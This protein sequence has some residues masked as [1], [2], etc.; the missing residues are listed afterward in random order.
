MKLEGRTALVTGGSRGIGRAACLAFAREGCD[1]VVNFAREADR[2]NAVVAE[3]ESLGRRALAAQGDVASE[4]EVDSVL[5]AVA[6]FVGD[7]GLNILFNNAGIYPRAT[8]EDVSV[9]EWDRVIGVN[10]RGPFLCT[11][12]A[13]PLLKAATPGRIINIGSVIPALGI[14]GAIHYSASKGAV[15]GFTHSLSRELAAFGIN[16]NCLVPSL[17]ETETTRRDYADLTDAVV[18]GQS[19][20]RY[21]QPGDL[22]GAL[23][24]LASDDSEFMTGQTLVVDGGRLLL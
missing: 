3:I 11:R 9:D 13:L 8:I 20:S 22:Q 2:A 23:V 6:E 1:V 5:A 12:A 10:V 4:D 19:V 16:V 14:P 15:V 17:V 24:F 7:R 21:Q 18:A